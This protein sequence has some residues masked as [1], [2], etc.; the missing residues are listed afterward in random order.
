MSLS[1]PESTL[2]SASEDR[3]V[4]Q[5]PAA[6]RELAELRSLLRMWLSQHSI[7]GEPADELLVV[8]S[9]IVTNAVEASPPDSSI[10]VCWA[11]DGHDV[12]MSV[13]DAGFGFLHT[14]AEPVSPASARGRGLVLVEALTD[15][16]DVTVEAHHTRVS[17]WTRFR[18]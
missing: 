11:I 16:L 15:R 4:L 14:A 5:R 3:V 1:G 18:P 10:T 17:T 12:F 8:V 2:S 7:N 6:L 13:E 9:E